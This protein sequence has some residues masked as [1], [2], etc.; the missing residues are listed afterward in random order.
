MK[1]KDINELQRYKQT[2]I[3]PRWWMNSKIERAVA[4]YIKLKQKN[5]KGKI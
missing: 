1:K 2:K 3:N 4:C 5:K